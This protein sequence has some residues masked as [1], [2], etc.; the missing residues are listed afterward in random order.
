[1]ASEIRWVR[2]AS[3]ADVLE[4][5][6]RGFPLGNGYIALHHLEGGEV[7]A[8]ADICSHEYARLSEGWLQGCVVECPLH[9]GRF[10]VRTGRAAGRP[11]TQDIAT[12]ETAVR[13]DEIWLKVDEHTLEKVNESGDFN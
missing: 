12:F 2:L 7:C 13:G 10:D 1:M 3:K 11:A 5:T 9:G 6:S 8:T 4:G